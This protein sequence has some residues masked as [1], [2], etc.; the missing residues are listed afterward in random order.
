M[1][2]E[3]NFKVG[4]ADLVTS[5]TEADKVNINEAIFQATFG[6]SDI[7]SSHTLLTGVRDGKLVP[8]VKSGDDFG[9]MA[10][11]DEKSCELNEC[12]LPT[13]YASKKWNLGEYN[14]RV[15]I[16]MRSF[17][18]DFLVFWNMYRQRLDNPLDTPDAQAFLDFLSDK[19]ERRIKGTSWRVAYFGD[20]DSANS[21]IE[22][23]D[24]F[25]VQALAGDGDKIQITQ[26]DPTGE[27]IYNYLSDAYEFASDKIW[28][29]ETDL[30]WKMTYKMASKLVSFLNKQADLS[31][32]NC[33]C[34]N[35]D[36]ITNTRRFTVSGLRVFGIP[37][38][39]HRELDGSLNALG[40][41]YTYQALLIRKSNLLIGTN[42]QD[43]ME[44]FDIFFDKKDRKIY[45]DMMVYIGASIPLDEEYVLITNQPI[46]S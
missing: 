20:E 39:A 31:P 1:A 22:N 37:V 42:T 12:D 18:E 17:D 28:F 32:Y 14:C 16:C 25:I 35:P 27:E 26:A 23:N 30:V 15:P 13:E 5:L 41:T 45:M 4:I 36:A 33:D 7:T 46:G 10:A 9:S 29:E 38:E 24:G 43:K 40:S 21:L 44:M 34:I 11:G 19:A 6:T 3:G 2:I 8:I